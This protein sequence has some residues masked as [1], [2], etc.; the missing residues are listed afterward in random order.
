MFFLNMS[1]FCRTQLDN[2]G[3]MPL[4]FHVGYYTFN[5]VEEAKY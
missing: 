4:A 5:L 2:N 3:Q 1:G